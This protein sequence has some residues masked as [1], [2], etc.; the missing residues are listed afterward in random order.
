MTKKKSINIAI[1]VAALVGVAALVTTLGG[2]VVQFVIK[3]HGG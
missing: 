3:M 2:R 1:W